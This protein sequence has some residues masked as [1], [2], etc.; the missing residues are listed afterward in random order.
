MIRKSLYAL[1]AACMTLG[2]FSTTLAVMT[3]QSSNA[4]EIA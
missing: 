2:T 3:G 1:A 4:V